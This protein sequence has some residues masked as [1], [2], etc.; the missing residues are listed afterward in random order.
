MIGSAGATVGA[1]DGMEGLHD[2]VHRSGRQRIDDAG[3]LAAGLHQAG[4]AQHRQVLRQRGLAELAAGL[5]LA[6]TGL[7][8][9]QLAEHQQALL[10]EIR[11]FP[12]QE[13]AS[14]AWA[15]ICCMGSGGVFLLVMAGLY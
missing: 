1:V 2:P 14:Q 4:I 8:V 10:A 6:D 12:G 13:Q 15:R 11:R 7:A 3:A 5:Q 9:H